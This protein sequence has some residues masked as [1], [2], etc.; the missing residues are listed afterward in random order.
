[1]TLDHT[2]G[3]HD[4]VTSGCCRSLLVMVGQNANGSLD[5]ELDETFVD[6]VH[7]AAKPGRGAC[8]CLVRS[9]RAEGPKEGCRP[10]PPAR[11]RDA[12]GESLVPFVCEI[13]HI[14]I[15]GSERRLG[16]RLAP[17]K[18]PRHRQPVSG[19]ASL[20]L[21]HAVREGVILASLLK[22]GVL[23]TYKDRSIRRTRRATSRLRSCC[24]AG[25]RAK[26]PR[27]DVFKDAATGP[28]AWAGVTQ[29]KDCRRHPKMS[30]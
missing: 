2:A 30:W 18:A 19:S 24:T 11:V 1:M 21:A 23:G 4:Q 20:D 29:G 3:V 16:P 8:M 10:G 12:S 27:I 28:V 5:A 6:G 14:S 17:R 15:G 13:A 26:R 9:A 22:Q 7:P 25:A